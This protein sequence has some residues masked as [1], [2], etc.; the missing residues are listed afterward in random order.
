MIPR[1]RIGIDVDRCIALTKTNPAAQQWFDNLRPA[2]RDTIEIVPL[3]EGLTHWQ[4]LRYE[5]PFRV[6]R[7]LEQL[8]TYTINIVT[9]PARPEWLTTITG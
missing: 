3:H 6:I 8:A 7:E 1:P 2:L 5:M 4:A 9:P